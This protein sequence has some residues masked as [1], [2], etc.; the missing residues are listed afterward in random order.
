MSLTELWRNAPTQFED[1]HLQQIIAFTG[2]GKLRDH[3]PTANEF[4]TFLAQIPSELLE[5]YIVECLNDNF[6]DSGLALQDLVNQLG[7][8]LG[9]RVENGL[10]RGRR[11]A[12]GFDGL[13]HFP[14]GHGVVVEIKTTDTYRIDT[15]VVA[16]YRKQLINAGRLEEDRSSILF[17]VGRQDTG[18]L[19]AQIRGSKHAWDVRLI[20]VQA[21]LN[22]LRLKESVDDPQLVDRICSILIPREFT[23]LDEIVFFATEEAKQE[24][25]VLEEADDPEPSII[26]SDSTHPATPATPPSAFHGACIE[27]PTSPSIPASG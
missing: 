6:P 2:D 7:H 1:K 24:A 9:F 15:D 5:R 12:I 11:N 17:V 4:R 3:A 10:Y 23:R 8:R 16:G 21:L 19:E 26:G 14:N 20:G 25:P 22:L 27:P 18:D 13:W